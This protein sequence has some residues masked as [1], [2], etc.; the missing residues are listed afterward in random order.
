MTLMAA[1]EAAAFVRIVVPEAPDMSATV[2][3]RGRAGIERFY[4]PP[5]YGETPEQDR[6]ETATMLDLEEDICVLPEDGSS[7]GAR[8]TQ[9]SIQMVISTGIEE[10]VR[11]G[12]CIVADG[13]L[14]RAFTGHHRRPILMQVITLHPCS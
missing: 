12:E 4:G 14:F 9:D 13:P 7:C 6:Q 2:S 8:D 10:N 1:H 5:N 3:L 11:A